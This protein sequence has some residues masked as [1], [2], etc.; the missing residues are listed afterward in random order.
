[1]LYDEFSAINKES[2]IQE[3]LSPP[4]WFPDYSI[5][6]TTFCKKWLALIILDPEFKE[7][8]VSMDELY[9]SLLYDWELHH[10]S[11]YIRGIPIPNP[12]TLSQLD[13]AAKYFYYKQV[14]IEAI[15]PSTKYIS[16]A[17][18]RRLPSQKQSPPPK[19]V[20]KVLYAISSIFKVLTGEESKD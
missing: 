14:E 7:K 13:D 19:R 20:N 1:M 11:N 18:P 10:Y 2:R 6:R 12:P 4:L 9:Q 17:Y 16:S 5:L 8:E 15:R 3:I